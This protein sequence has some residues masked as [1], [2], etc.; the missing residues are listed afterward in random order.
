MSTNE[1]EEPRH[2]LVASDASLALP[3]VHW[4]CLNFKGNPYL[5]ESS[6]HEVFAYLSLV[7]AFAATD[8]MPTLQRFT[9]TV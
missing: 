3:S 4:T 7:E 5:A 1:V 8:E 6:K 9:R 2:K